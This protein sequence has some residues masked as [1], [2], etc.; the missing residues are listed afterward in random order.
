M[1]RLERFNRAI[2]VEEA[3]GVAPDAMVRLA[4]GIEDP[5]DLVD[6]LAA[7]SPGTRDVRNGLVLTRVEARAGSGLDRA[8]A[9][10]VEDAVEV[11]GG[12]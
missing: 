1:P 12:H 2:A 7:R 9:L 3:L 8:D 6:D 4:L 10:A 5:G 11:G